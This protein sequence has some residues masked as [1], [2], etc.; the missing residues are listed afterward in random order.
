MVVVDESAKCDLW[1]MSIMDALL[2]DKTSWGVESRIALL[3][4]PW[5]PAVFKSCVCM[6]DSTNEDD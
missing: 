5:F 6:K 3:F 2:P 1:P 4:Q